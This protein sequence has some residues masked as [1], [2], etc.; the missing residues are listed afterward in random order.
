MT[1]VAYGAIA[2][3]KNA[4]AFSVRSTSISRSLV[5]SLHNKGID[6]YAWTVDSRHNINRMIDLGVDNIIT[7]NIPLAIE[8]INNSRTGTALAEIQRMIR[9]LF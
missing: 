9:E 7:N 1:G 5:R 2:R 8:C 6:V 4:N 3:L